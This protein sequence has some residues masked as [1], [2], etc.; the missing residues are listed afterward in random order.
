MD[1]IYDKYSQFSYLR[2]KSSKVVMFTLM[3]EP[4][5]S[6]KFKIG[7]KLLSR[8]ERNEAGIFIGLAYKLKI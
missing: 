8:P 5:S 2:G 3:G 4:F 6:L 1:Y 7:G